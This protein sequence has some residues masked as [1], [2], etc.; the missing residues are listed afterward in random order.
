MR[1]LRMLLMGLLKARAAMKETRA[2]TTRVRRRRA[3]NMR[4]LGNDSCG[5]KFE[6]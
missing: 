5:S 1:R 6:S 4:N 2:E 3:K